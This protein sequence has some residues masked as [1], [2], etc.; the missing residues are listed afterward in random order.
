[1]TSHSFRCRIHPAVH[2]HVETR[3]LDKRLFGFIKKVASKFLG[4]E[5]EPSEREL[6]GLVAREFEEVDAYV[7]CTF[8]PR[9]K[10]DLLQYR[11]PRTR[12][13]SIRLYQESR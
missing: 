6:D 12:Q 4:R 9:M 11:N 2:H 8:H 5:V 1:M 7:I 10:A 3:E 13:A